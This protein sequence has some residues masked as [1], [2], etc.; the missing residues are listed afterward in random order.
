MNVFSLLEFSI[1]QDV[2][3]CVYIQVHVDLTLNVVFVGEDD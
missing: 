2:E 3:F 1:I